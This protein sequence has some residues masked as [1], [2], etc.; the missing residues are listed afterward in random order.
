MKHS[1]IVL[2]SQRCPSFIVTYPFQEILFVC[3]LYSRILLYGHPFIMGAR[4]G[5]RQLSIITGCPYLEGVRKARFDCTSSK[6]IRQRTDNGQF[7]P[8]R[9]KQS[10]TKSTSL[11]RT[12]CLILNNKDV[13]KW[14]KSVN[15]T[16]T[17]T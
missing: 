3:S 7:F 1:H 5:Q 16:Y 15:Y 4:P 11:I 12:I 17:I 13:L 8:S 6:Q 14:T 9:L 10:H 2:G